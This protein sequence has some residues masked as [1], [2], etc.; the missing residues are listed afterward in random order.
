ML[1]KQ[2]HVPLPK[3]FVDGDVIVSDP[4]H[5]IAKGFNDYFANIGPMMASTFIQ[6]D[7]FAEYL[8]E[9][10]H[11]RF[12]FS[13]VTVTEI[14]DL[15]ASF[16]SSSPGCDK[17]PMN[18]FKDN[19]HHLFEIITYVCNLSFQESVFPKR[20]MIAIV[21]CIFKSGDPHIYKNYR[22]ISILVAFREILE[23]AATNR[24]LTYFASKNLFTEFQFGFRPGVSTGDAIL[25][26]VTDIYNSFD[27]DKSTVGVFLRLIKG[28]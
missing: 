20:L 3:Y 18:I 22:S 7:S 24:L 6:D 2:G 17:I 14:S 1:G 15:I 28:L 27:L 13:R 8:N 4:P 23:K 21:T 12:V 9:Q 5:D 10:I 25:N 11:D 19:I 26:V 16:K